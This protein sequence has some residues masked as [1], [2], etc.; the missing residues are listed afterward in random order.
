MRIQGKLE[1]M[2]C[3]EISHIFQ[4]PKRMVLSSRDTA[5]PAAPFSRF[6]CWAHRLSWGVCVCKCNMP[7]ND[8]PP[9]TGQQEDQV[10]AFNVNIES[11]L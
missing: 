7:S 2:G 4:N 9:H 11:T 10:L 8:S 3:S 1:I 5:Q 6:G